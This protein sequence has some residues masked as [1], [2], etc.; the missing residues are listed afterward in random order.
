MK[1]TRDFEYVMHD[2]LR[3]L[4]IREEYF[5]CGTNSQYDRMFELSTDPKFSPREVAIMIY[6]CSDEDAD[7]DTIESQVE[8]ITNEI[9]E[10]E[11]SL[12]PHR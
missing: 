1:V 10:M 4:C 2:R 6:M 8:E 3:S 11:E 12:H 5:T 9:H 7:L